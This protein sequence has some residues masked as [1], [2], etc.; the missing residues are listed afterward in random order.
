[1]KAE[2]LR[3]AIYGLLASV[4]TI[5]VFYGWIQQE[6][7]PLWLDTVDRAVTVVAFV[8]AMKNVR[9]RGNSVV[10]N[11]PVNRLSE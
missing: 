11:E 3:L 2:N 9:N 10:T 7:L 6:A 5:M 4:G 8:L 1:M